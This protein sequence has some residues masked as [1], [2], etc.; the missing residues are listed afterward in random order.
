MIFG[1]RDRAPSGKAPQI[2]TLSEGRIGAPVGSHSPSELQIRDTA[3]GSPQPRSRLTPRRRW[4]NR[5]V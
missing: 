5:S 3:R 2:M 1:L 4:S